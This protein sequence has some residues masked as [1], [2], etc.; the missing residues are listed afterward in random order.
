MSGVIIA[1][2]K[3][4]LLLRVFPGFSISAYEFLNLQIPI[5]RV[6]QTKAGIHKSH[7]CAACK[8]PLLGYYIGMEAIGVM[9]YAGTSELGL[10]TCQTRAVVDVHLVRD[11]IH[12]HAFTRGADGAFI[13][14][15]KR[16]S[17]YRER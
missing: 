10:G 16:G 2:K 9:G 17:V 1:A 4:Y 6:A 13:A 11:V 12:A 14:K 5:R 15:N 7:Y 8:Y 3:S